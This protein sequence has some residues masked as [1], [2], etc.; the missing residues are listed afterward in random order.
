[1]LDFMKFPGT[2]FQR[3]RCWNDK[4]QFCGLPNG[5]QCGLL[6]Q[7]LCGGT[8]L[9]GSTGG[10]EVC[11]FFGFPWDFHGISYDSK[12]VFLFLVD[13]FVKI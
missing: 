11:V 4:A 13:I 2:F 6:G 7:H 1:M 12:I 9:S 10:D 5:F 3:W 8:E